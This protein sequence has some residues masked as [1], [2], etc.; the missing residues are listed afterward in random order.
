[1]P[2]TSVSPHAICKAVTG[3]PTARNHF[4]AGRPRAPTHLERGL[5]ERIV[6][7]QTRSCRVRQRDAR[8]SLLGGKALAAP[9]RC[10]GIGV[11]DDEA[12]PLEALLVVDLGAEQIRHAE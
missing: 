12:S 2:R 11:L 1:M 8:Y 9:A 5:A 4:V 7:P 6:S 10:A 3:S